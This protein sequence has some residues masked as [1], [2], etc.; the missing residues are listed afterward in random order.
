MGSEHPKSLPRGL[1]GGVGGHKAEG[2]G[3]KVGA[4][5]LKTPTFSLEKGLF[6]LKRPVFPT[7]KPNFPL[8]IGV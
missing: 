4:S 3:P 8:K 1:G 2:L 5:V 7:Q 6:P